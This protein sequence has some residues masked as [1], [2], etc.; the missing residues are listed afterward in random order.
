[1]TGALKVVWDAAPKG[2]EALPHP[3]L[4]SSSTALLSPEGT[5]AREGYAT[6][7]L[8]HPTDLIQ[9]HSMNWNLILITIYFLELLRERMV[10]SPRT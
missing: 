5:Q 10:N 7:S 3:G 1:M 8:A 6:S 9:F 4:S 2:W